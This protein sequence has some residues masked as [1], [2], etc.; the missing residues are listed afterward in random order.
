[1]KPC[2]WNVLFKSDLSIFYGFV[3]LCFLGQNSHLSHKLFYSSV[4]SS[5]QNS[6][7][8]VRITELTENQQHLYGH[9]SHYVTP[10]PKLVITL[11]ID[12]INNFSLNGTLRLGIISI[13]L[14]VNLF[15]PRQNNHVGINHSMASALIE[16]GN[17]F[18]CPSLGPNHW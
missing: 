2:R 4:S 14:P 12:G 1:M 17:A 7:T 3:K 18:F 16:N 6:E 10:H 15:C 8:A 13:C 11:I 5:P 9:W